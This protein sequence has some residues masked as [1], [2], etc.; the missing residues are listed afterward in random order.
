MSNFIIP[1]T[2]MLIALTIGFLLGGIE[3][4]GEPATHAYL[5]K[6]WAALM[7]LIP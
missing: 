2:T 6:Q 7:A 3:I 5:N 1:L 4:S